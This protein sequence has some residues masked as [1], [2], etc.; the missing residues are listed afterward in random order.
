MLQEK[1]ST[2]P[3]DNVVQTK[4]VQEPETDSDEIDLVDIYLILLKHKSIALFSFLICLV[5]GIAS[6]VFSSPLYKS[7]AVVAIGSLGKD[8]PIQDRSFLIQQLRETFNVHKGSAAVPRIEKLQTVSRDAKNVFTITAVASTA[9]DAQKFLK[10]KLGPLFQQHKALFDTTVLSW[11]EHETLLKQQLSRID[12]ALLELDQENSNN[13]TL[14][15]QSYLFMRS[16]VIDSLSKLK[17][18]NQLTHVFPSKYLASPSLSSEPY[19]PRIALSLLISVIAGLVLALC[20][21]FVREFFHNLAL[22][23]NRRKRSGSWV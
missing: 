23:V 7:Q 11:Q 9:D 18:E 17:T 10:Q 19:K 1:N 6:V 20:L 16:N 8:N 21:V 2:S 3:S 13:K 22:K 5:I 12:Q 4:F 14:E 15:K